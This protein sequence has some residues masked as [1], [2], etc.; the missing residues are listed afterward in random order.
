[1]T[2][3]GEN[4]YNPCLLY[5]SV[6]TYSCAWSIACTLF[7]RQIRSFKGRSAS[8]QWLWPFQ[9]VF[10]VSVYLTRS[11]TCF[12]FL[13]VLYW[14]KVQSNDASGTKPWSDRSYILPIL[15]LLY[16]TYP[17][18]IFGIKQ[19]ERDTP[20]NIDHYFLRFIFISHCNHM[21]NKPFQLLVLPR[22][23]FSNL[24]F[25]RYTLKHTVL[26]KVTTWQGKSAIKH[27]RTLLI[28]LFYNF[29]LILSSP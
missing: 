22:T 25:H 15:D 28:T 9:D 8:A 10:N 21:A 4:S 14:N 13:F 11:L 2:M 3:L 16:F 12:V 18:E 20:A 23:C 5:D 7:N 17:V 19:K 29:Y 6:H 24:W 27:Q 26:C 1:M